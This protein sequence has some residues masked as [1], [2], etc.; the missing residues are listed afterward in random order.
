MKATPEELHLHLRLICRDDPVVT[1]ELAATIY[2]QVVR[3]ARARLGFR[4]DPVLVEEAAGQAILD[5]YGEPERYDPERLPLCSYLA[6]MARQRYIK[7]WRRE[8]RW[9]TQQVWL[10]D[11]ASWDDEGLVALDSIED[12]ITR[13]RFE[14]V[15]PLVDAE[16]PDP[17]ERAVLMLIINGV[18]ETT[19]YVRAIGLSH[20]PEDEQTQQ[21]ERVK[22]RV[23]KRLRRIGEKLNE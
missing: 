11:D 2:D 12:V 5:Y 23:K 10:T 21:V 7:A 13:L 3:T 20:L 22:N 14:E 8:Q 1:A 16:F 9:E 17:I 19:V 6:M 18:R 15:W 4:A